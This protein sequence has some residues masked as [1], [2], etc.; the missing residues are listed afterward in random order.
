MPRK[1]E[2][3]AK[4][5]PVVAHKIVEPMEM[6]NAPDTPRVMKSTGPAEKALDPVLVQGVDRPV[7][8][9]KLAMLKFM[10]EPVTIHIHET[11]NKQDD[12]VFEFIIGGRI[13]HFMRGETKTVPRFVVDRM[14][15]CKPTTYTDKEVVNSEGVKDMVYTPHTGLRYPFSVMEDPHPR[16]REWLMHTM[17]ERA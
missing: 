17:R 4:N 2:R 11:T 7:D 14:A 16:G 9:E 12:Q 13:Y 10:A 6:E 15:R 8:E 5:T 1:Y 3:Q